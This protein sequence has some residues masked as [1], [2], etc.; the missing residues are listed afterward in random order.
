MIYCFLLFNAFKN[1]VLLLVID[2][3]RFKMFCDLLK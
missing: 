2:E 1:N 3:I